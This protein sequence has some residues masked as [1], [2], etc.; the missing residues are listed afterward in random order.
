MGGSRD[1][2]ACDETGRIWDVEGLYVADAAALPGNT[3][4]N[5]QVT[6]MANALRIAG[7]IAASRGGRA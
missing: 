1:A 2:S 5:P 6:I 3:G 4:A 7:G